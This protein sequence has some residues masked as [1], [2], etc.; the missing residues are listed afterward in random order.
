M[1]GQVVQGVRMAEAR[2]RP[3]PAN[4]VPSASPPFTPDGKSQHLTEI[5]IWRA[6]HTPDDRLFTV[7]NHKGQEASTLTCIQLLRRAE[8]LACLLQ[9]RG[10]ASV[11]SVVSLLYPP[12]IEL[13][14]AFYACLLIGAIPVPVRPPRVEQTQDASV[15]GHSGQSSTSHLSGPPGSGSTSALG[16]FGPS[17]SAGQFISGSTDSWMS[18]HARPPFPTFSSSVELIWNVVNHSGTSVIL[19]QQSI[20]KLLKS[21]EATNKVPYGHWPTILDSEETFRKKVPPL[22]QNPCMEQPIAYLDFVASTT[23]TITGIRVTHEVAYALCRAQKVQCEFYPTRE[24]VLCLDPY[25]GLGFTLWTLTSVHCGHHS[26]LVPPG[27]S[28]IV[29]DLW[30]TVCSQRK[31]RDAFC[32]H[33]TMELATRY[34]AKHMSL[35]KHRDLT[36]SSLRSLVVVAEE[37][38]RVHLTAM[39]CKLFSSVGL[40]GRAVT[41]SFG[42]RVNLAI[43]LQGASSPESTTV[44][45][46]RISLRNDRIKLL[47]KG[48]PNSMCLM[49][50][51]K[52]LPGVHVAIANPDTFGQCA[53]SQLGEIWVS[54]PH[55]STELLGPF[56]SAS[57]SRAPGSSSQSVVGSNATDALHARL[58]TGDTG[59][60]YART[61]FLGFVR[62]TELTQSDGELHDAIFVVGSLEEA[63]MLRGMRF[64]PVDIESTVMRAHKKICEW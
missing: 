4:S 2:G 14:C 17:G 58:V 50:S 53:D 37:R 5:L 34:M 62:R 32:S 26:I 59:R 23:G 46:D 6:T 51:G 52:L 45:V 3:L 54:S 8:R 41:T 27:I 60:V 47:E 57:L 31:V 36:L 9:E 12:G 13:V 39:F 44:Y 30:L 48:S 1:C 29:P 43:S 25:S 42:C 38:P 55:N 28:E 56:D 35:S 16:L 18:I 40:V 63:I 61:G 11:G 49:E 24:V 20:I 33:V 22:H 21:K 19:T 64:H 10:R 7:Y 15:G